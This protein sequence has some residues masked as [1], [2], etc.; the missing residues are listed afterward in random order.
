MLR[1]YFESK[2]ET[3]NAVINSFFIHKGVDMSFVSHISGIDV[4]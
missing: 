3:T 2:S 1:P 4:Y